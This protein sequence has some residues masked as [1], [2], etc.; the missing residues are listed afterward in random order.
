MYNFILDRGYFCTLLEFGRILQCSVAERVQSTV[1][2]NN[3]PI[4]I[5]FYQ[6]D[7]LGNGFISK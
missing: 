7:G 3:F 4:N 2:R 5:A 6:P 1:N